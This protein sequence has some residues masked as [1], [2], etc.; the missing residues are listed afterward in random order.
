MS[1]FPAPKRRRLSPPEDGLNDE[2]LSKRL[3]RSKKST[4]WNQE[5]DYE[6]R[7]RKM[8]GKSKEVTRLPIKT[9]EGWIEQTAPVAERVE[10]SDSF[11]GTEDEGSEDEETE[12]EGEV[13]P[14]KIS[15]RKQIL[16]AKEKLYRLAALI[17]EDPEEN[18]GSLKSLA[19]VAA[20]ENVTIKKLAL[21]T[22]CAVYKD[23][24]PG[25]RIR[26]IKEGEQKEVLS[27]EVRKLRNYEQALAGGYQ[28]YVKELAKYAKEN[29]KDTAETDSTLST[30]AITC[31]C[32]LLVSVPHFNFRAEILGIL[33]NKLSSRQMNNDFIK[34]RETLERLFKD[35]EDG[36]ASM[37]AVSMLT[38]MIKSR[39][40]NIDESILNTFLHLRLLSE[41]S[42]KASNSRVDKPEKDTKQGKKTR[43]KREF[44]TKKQ[45]KL[46]RENKAIE[47]EFK[48]AD[49]AVSH[50][51]RDKMQAE[52]LKLVFV[53]YFRI[54]KARIPHL[55]GAVLE[56]LAKYAHLINQEFFGDILEALKDLITQAETLS[57]HSSPDTETPEVPAFYNPTRASLLCITTAFA[58]L[59]GQEAAKA[60]STLQ[61]D[62]TFFTTHLYRLLLPLSVSPA[63]E[64]PLKSLPQHTDSLQTDDTKAQNK[65]N[66]Q[67]TPVLL[68]RALTSTLLPPHSL[69]SIPPIR[70]AA[71][72]KR[73]MLTSLHL[74]E[75]PCIALLGLLARVTKVHGAKLAALWN[76]EERRGNGV[77]DSQGGDVEASNPFAASVWEGEVLRVHFSPG[78]RE[79]LGV[80]VEGVKVEGGGR[81]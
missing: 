30:V 67:T 75:K 77:Y 10:G 78:V 46:L 35:D 36:N 40:Y 2:S 11:L 74:P 4:R 52:S 1:R 45:R 71:F 39:N 69:R 21:A 42:Y 32:D 56:G 16:E 44:R 61:L 29:K 72:T 68:I 47:K 27:K 19:Q 25:Y 13:E 62:L 51:E 76:T 7:P 24:I 60:A 23:I 14:P 33:L 18:A 20:S 53:T 49:A 48:E 55:M 6:Q 22:Q 43:E 38:K 63:I 5:Q 3:S 28:D 79:A 64:P 54:L 41:F 8:A 58:L 80:V 50:E 66:A 81:R 57:E 73:L 31:A 70:L 37:E 12:Q 17:N 9:S 34:C 26:P 15:V 59:Q 65:V